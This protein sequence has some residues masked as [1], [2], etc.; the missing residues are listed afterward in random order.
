MATSS[1]ATS[2]G[3]PGSRRPPTAARSCSRTRRGR[4]SA[5]AA[6]RRRAARPRRAPAQGPARPRAA[7]RSSW[8]TACPV[9]FPPLRSLDA[10]PNNLPTQ[11]TTFVG[12][13][14]RAR[15]GRRAARADP[16]ADAHRAGRH[17]QDAAV[18]PDRGRRRRRFP[19]RRL[20]R[21]R[22]SRSATGARRA[23]DRRGRS[24]SPTSGPAGRCD[25]IAD[26]VGRRPRA[27]RPRQLRA[28]DRRGPGRRRP[29]ARA[30]PDL[31]VLVTSRTA[32]RVY[33]RAGVPRA[34]PARATRSRARS[35]SSSGSTC[36]RELRAVDRGDARPVRG[37]P[38][39]HR[40][41][42]RRPARLRGDERE[43]AGRRAGS[44]ARLHGMPL[45]IELAAARVKLL[46]PEQILARLE[47]QLA[48]AVVRLARPAGA[49]ADAA[50]RD[51]LEL[52]PARRRDAAGCS[53]GWPCSSAACELDVAEASAA[54]PTRSASTSSTGSATLVDQSLAPAS[55][56]ATDEPRFAM[57]ETIREFA[58]EMLTAQ[59]R[60]RRHRS[61]RQRDAF[62][63]LAER[64]A[65]QLA[66]ADQ[67]RWLDRLEREHDN[68]RAP[69][70]DWAADRPGPAS[71]A[72]RVAFAL[73]RFWQKRGLPRR[74]AAPAR[75]DGGR[76][77][78]PVDPVA[79][80]AARR[81]ARR[82]RLVAGATRRP[83]RPGTTRRSRSG[84]R[85]AT[86]ARSPT[87]STTGPTPT[88]SSDHARAGRRRPSVGGRE[89][90][91]RRRCAIYRELG[92]A[93]A[94]ATSCG[95]SAA[96]TTSRR[97][98][99]RE[100]AYR[101]ALG[102]TARP[103]TG[104]WRP[105]RCTCSRS[106]LVSQRRVDEAEGR[107]PRCARHFQEAGDVAGITLVL[108]DLSVV[109]LLDGDLPRAGRLWGAAR[110]LQ[111]DDRRGP[112]D[113]STRPA[114]DRSGTPTASE[115]LPPDDL[116]RYAAEGAAM[117][118]D[119]AVAYALETFQAAAEPRRRATM[120]TDRARSALARATCR[121]RPSAFVVLRRSAAGDRSARSR[122][123]VILTC[124]N[125]GARWTSASA[126]SS[127]RCG[128]FRPART[129]TEAPR[130]RGSRAMAE[131]IEPIDPDGQHDGL[132]RGDLVG[133]DGSGAGRRM[134]HGGDAGRSDRRAVS[135]RLRRRQ[136]RQRHDPGARAGPAVRLQLGM[137]GRRAG[138]GDARRHGPSSR[139]P[140][141]ARRSRSSTA[142]G[143]RPARTR[144]PGTITR[145]TGRAISRT[146]WRC[147]TR[148][149]STRLRAAGH[150][151][152]PAG[153]AR[154]ALR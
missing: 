147:S 33:G 113:P 108:D 128:Y 139:S 96:T 40:P 98:P 47:H 121:A 72:V 69:L 5:T 81:G 23:D 151:H 123:L 146:W 9:D 140:V 85:S 41:G 16:A 130:T 53:T 154:L 30:A 63:D 127:A 65:P 76:G 66:G 48:R 77:C 14:R 35:P 43:R 20:V 67:R 78:G 55:K 91:S 46:S 153:W 86:D 88:R 90:C 99:R 73:W 106:S 32:L 7:L 22:S 93:A 17:R 75:G 29:A 92:D 34:G 132:T 143:R 112:C 2:T 101:E 126:S 21:R 87:P 95:V 60:M 51:R 52:R 84:G 124:A 122:A 138:R 136:R 104:R 145:A 74:G 37:G 26:G 39:V 82:R 62:L 118:L 150:R 45:A 109:A 100:P 27:A 129:T 58:A 111:D 80:G 110:H 13:E 102:S 71:I 125:C 42:Q 8:S 1:A 142:A 61:D 137:G 116:E 11:L 19:R 115:V 38:A 50:R 15:R 89:R 79:A 149:D 103:A 70:M 3:R 68:L 56:R 152:V 94:R 135:A 4:W 64:A 141:E 12:R 6:E 107:G 59:R 120:R 131:P 148:P 25:G 24:A 83:P 105:G 28:G 97:T 144:R 133:A 10:R 18:A 57:L 134:V 36:R 117:S 44:A 119:E 114:S 54:R 31:A 49:P